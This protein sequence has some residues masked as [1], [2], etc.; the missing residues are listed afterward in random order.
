[1]DIL[2]SPILWLLDKIIPQLAGKFRK[3]KLRMVVK[4]DR[5]YQNTIKVSRR[6]DGDF[7]TSFRVAIKNDGNGILKQGEGYW[8]LY[9]PSVS[10]V[11]SDSES[12]Q[13]IS[14]DLEHIRGLISLP[15]FQKSFLDI[16][17]EFKFLVRKELIDNFK[18]Y[19][20]FE[21]NYGYFPRTAKINSETA[22][23]LYEDMSSIPIEIV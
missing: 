11:V 15:V 10:K 2:I 3:P 7:E 22:E 8:H 1:M 12:K 9:F 20:F 13:F 16:G 23:V 6:D 19:Y 14:P 4:H 5:L 18:I 21:T 17:P